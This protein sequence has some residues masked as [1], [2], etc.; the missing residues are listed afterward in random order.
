MKS[1]MKIVCMRRLCG[2][3]GRSASPSTPRTVLDITNWPIRNTDATHRV[4]GCYL[5]ARTAHSLLR[6]SYYT[7]VLMNLQTHWWRG[8]MVKLK[9]TKTVAGPYLTLPLHIHILYFVNS[10]T[11]WPLLL[12]LLALLLTHREK[13]AQRK[14]K[15]YRKCLKLFHFSTYSWAFLKTLKTLPTYTDT[16]THTAHAR[17]PP[18]RTHIYKTK[19]EKR[20]WKS[21]GRRLIITDGGEANE[22][23]MVF[24][25]CFLSMPRITCTHICCCWCWM[26]KRQAS[27]LLVMFR[28]STE[29]EAAWGGGEGGR[30]GPHILCCRRT[31]FYLRV[32]LCLCAACQLINWIRHIIQDC[33]YTHADSSLCVVFDDHVAG[34]LGGR[35]DGRTDGRM[36][37]AE[38]GEKDI[39]KNV[40]VK[41]QKKKHKHTL[42]RPR[43]EV[44][45]CWSWNRSRALYAIATLPKNSIALRAVCADGDGLSGYHYG[46]WR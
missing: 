36:A 11:V 3:D 14:I 10:K 21:I 22:A 18:P 12:L 40:H 38:H 20:K 24:R 28:I 42:T 34:L 9:G 2:G 45:K 23:E 1:E 16:H 37:W 32:C 31:L 6:I 35:V 8:A 30:R 39:K 29:C 33:T 15:I 19:K 46:E 17:S 43:N 26:W 27:R 25:L 7:C 13:G 4:V 41:N 44:E 5:C